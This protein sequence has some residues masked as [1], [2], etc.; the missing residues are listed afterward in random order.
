MSQE[1][2]QRIDETLEQFIEIFNT[3]DPKRWSEI[4][5]YPHLQ[6]TPFREPK[7]FTTPEV[8][9]AATDFNRMVEMGWH[10][11]TWDFK[12]LVQVSENKVHAFGQYTRYKD[13][14][15]K[16]HANTTA[17]ILTRVN[18]Q[19][20]IQARFNTGLFLHPLS[21]EADPEEKAKDI[22]KAYFS[23]DGDGAMKKRSDLFHFPCFDIHDDQVEQFDS[24]PEGGQLKRITDLRVFQKSGAAVNIAVESA[25]NG[26]TADKEKI[27]REIFIVI[28][29]NDRWGIMARSAL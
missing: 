26:S 4:L 25:I 2:K 15:G 12:E 21:A 16:L 19:W 10:H 27:K 9:A 23:A 17:Y 7:V 29:K 8:Y 14:G 5:H 1:I 11:S 18:G 6:C 3:R 22:I 28:L 24:Y 13:D 20:G